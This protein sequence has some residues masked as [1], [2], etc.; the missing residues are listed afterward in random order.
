M[1]NIQI[2]LGYDAAD[3]MAGKDKKTVRSRRSRK[4]IIKLTKENN[5]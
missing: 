4:A 3:I 5:K 2:I 1:R